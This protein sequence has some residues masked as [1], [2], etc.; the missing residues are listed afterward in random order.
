[1]PRKKIVKASASSFDKKNVV[2]APKVTKV[3]PSVSRLKELVGIIE[4]F[5]EDVHIEIFQ[6][7]KKY[8]SSKEFTPNDNGVY[9]NLCSINDDGLIELDNFVI[10]CK[11]NNEELMKREKECEAVRK[12]LISESGSSDSVEKDTDTDV[13]D[14]EGGNILS[15]SD[16]NNVSL[17]NN[18]G[19]TDDLI[20]KDEGDTKEGI[21]VVKGKKKRNDAKKKDI[22]LAGAKVSLHK[23]KSK[24][25]GLKAKIIKQHKTGN[26]GDFTS[27]GSGVN[28]SAMAGDNGSVKSEVSG[29]SKGNKASSTIKSKRAA[30]KRNVKKLMK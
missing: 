24:F 15:L 18:S 29:S 23:T 28:L 1:M 12:N 30:A 3:R 5:N 19:N 27:E 13:E 11:K 7:M 10:F 22:D 17:V 6:M 26:K 14:I 21:V 20:G 8:M 9:F 4:T 16:E 25:T 2:K